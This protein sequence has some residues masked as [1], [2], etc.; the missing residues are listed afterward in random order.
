MSTKAIKFNVT[1]MRPDKLVENFEKLI[2]KGTNMKFEI[3]EIQQETTSQST[4][5]SSF[6]FPITLYATNGFI[7][8]ITGLFLGPNSPWNEPVISLLQK[9]GF[10][11]KTHSINKIKSSKDIDITLWKNHQ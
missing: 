4:E 9:H 6:S 7:I 1:G 5:I 10:N 8:K 2:V 3:A 11:I